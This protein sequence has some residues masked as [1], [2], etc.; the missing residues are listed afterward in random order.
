MAI[1]SAYNN[2]LSGLN[3]A[4]RASTLVSENLANALTP[5]FGRRSLE[6]GT[7]TATGGVRVLG[8][9]RHGDPAL[10]TNRRS[11]DA[12]QAS[13]A[14]FAAF[15]SRLETLTGTA[16]DPQAITARL[17]EFETSLIAAASM[18]GSQQRLDQS[19]ADAKALISAISGAADGLRDLR[20]HADKNIGLQVDRINVLLADIQELNIDITSVGSS[21]GNTN[22]LLDHRQVLIDELNKMIPVNVLNRDHGQIALYSQGGA[23]LLDGNPAELSFSP[24]T[25]VMPHMTLE[26]GFLSGLEI[27]GV[28]VRTSG[29]RNALIGGSLEA[30]FAI[31][32]DLSVSAQQD[33]D[34]LA[35]DLIKRFED[36][37]LD[38]TL[39][40]GDAGL[41]TD[42][43]SALD[44]AQEIGLAGRLEINA[45]VD[46]D[47]GGNSWRLRAGLGAADPG[48]PGDGRLLQGYIDA[49][50]DG[51]SLASGS[52]GSGPMSAA[53]V[54]SGL[55]ATISLQRS[56]ADEALSFAATHQTEM[57]RIELEQ[58]VDTDAELQSLMAVEQAYAAN[59][60]VIEALESMMDTILRL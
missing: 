34:A 26:N 12:G 1:T 59:A 46:P 29:S 37:G 43:G 7:N 58:G 21:G 54:A 22:A 6:L 47:A 2:A 5:G 57:S 35:R 56:G 24:T 20:T 3:A 52:F 45:L 11:A 25:E 60:R 17:A 39:S 15:F 49:L 16:T 53:D 36:P 13:A 8:I 4:R 41:F 55:T 27:N 14:A 42:G 40:V 19:V 38:P 50:D 18:P 10:L 44:S 30:E 28:P 31:R 51:R 33:L 9:V 23:I 48:E 32:D